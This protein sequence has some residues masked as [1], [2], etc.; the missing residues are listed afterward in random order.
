MLAHR[1]ME[2]HYFFFTEVCSNDWVPYQ[3][4][5]I[6]FIEEMDYTGCPRGYG[7]YTDISHGNRLHY[8]TKLTID[9]I[10]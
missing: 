1:E 8:F 5:A 6:P 7:T 4:S 2:I 9:K 10:V 3:H